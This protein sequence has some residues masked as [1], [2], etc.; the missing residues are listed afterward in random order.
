MLDVGQPFI[1]V[2]DWTQTPMAFRQRQLNSL[3]W[4]ALFALPCGAWQSGSK[5]LVFDATLLAHTAFVGISCG[6]VHV[7]QT[8]RYR[9]E[10]IIEGRLSAREV[11]VSHSACDGDVFRN[12]AIGSRVRVDARRNNQGRELSESEA[13]E[14]GYEYRRRPERSRYFSAEPPVPAGDVAKRS[15]WPAAQLAHAAERAPREFVLDP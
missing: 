7:M 4:I 6:R 10:R 1:S 3:L 12:L 15:L 9:V 8:A 2:R 13:V 11:L 5:R 14:L